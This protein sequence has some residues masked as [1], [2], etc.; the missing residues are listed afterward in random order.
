MIRVSLPGRSVFL[1]QSNSGCDAGR[2]SG[3]DGRPGIALRDPTRTS[4]GRPLSK[5]PVWPQ[6]GRN[7]HSIQVVWGR[8]DRHAR[9][10]ESG[11]V[12]YEVM[13]TVGHVCAR[14]WYCVVVAACT[15]VWSRDGMCPV[16]P[17]RVLSPENNPS[18]VSQRQNHSQIRRML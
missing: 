12:A 7:Y 3:A 4:T 17:K 1:A 16:L 15:A 6:F 9:R 13:R 14:S 10:F 5:L 18:R 11:R 8:L 2:H